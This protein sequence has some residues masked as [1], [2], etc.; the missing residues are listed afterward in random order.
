MF[1]TLLATQYSI[2]LLSLSSCLCCTVLCYFTMLCLRYC[3]ANLWQVG[4]VDEKIMETIEWRVSFGLP[5]I[6]QSLVCQKMGVEYK[7]KLFLCV[8]V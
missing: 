1:V 7:N 3:S 5:T 8:C 4:N 6:E 2:C